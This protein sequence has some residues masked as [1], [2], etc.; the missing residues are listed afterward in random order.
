M[1]L[2]CLSNKRNKNTAA[3]RT[4]IYSLLFSLFLAIAVFSCG[5]AKIESAPLK[6]PKIENKVSWAGIYIRNTKIGW[7]KTEV[8]QMEQNRFR[9]SEESFMRIGAMGII[10]ESK[11]NFSADFNEDFNPLAYSFSMITPS[12]TM[13]AKGEIKDNV[14]HMKISTPSGETLR[15]VPIDSNT[16]LFGLADLKRAAE[17]YKVGDV[18][19]GKMFE[20]NILGIVP[21]KIEVID[22]SIVKFGPELKTVFKIR[23]TIASVEANSLVDADGSLIL[24]EGP[25]GITMKREP[26]EIA[27]DLSNSGNIIYLITAFSLDAGKFVDNPSSIR[28]AK[29]QI[30]GLPESFDNEG[31]QSISESDSDG[32]RMVTVDLDSP[33]PFSGSKEEWLMPTDYVQ[34]DDSRII[35]KAV[36]ITKGAIDHKEKSKI[37][38]D[39]V[40]ANMHREPAFTIP[41]ALDVLLSMKGD[42]NEH[43][44]LYC[45]L[46]RAAGIPAR[47]ATGI[48]YLDGRF[49]YHAWNEVLL[50]GSWFP[51][52]STF[53]EFPAGALRIRFSSG[54]LMDQFKIAG[55]AGKI[56][57]SILEAN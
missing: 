19:E 1:N 24:S 28:R 18:F 46:A 43:S 29:I 37:I 32:N 41:S 33:K 20:P 17:G 44:A 36:E 42:C 13:T 39:W 35:N 31:V 26:E 16:D 14:L 48:V 34:S 38:L 8:K 52:D 22:S 4:T 47:T 27:K 54:E 40:H 7:S 50:D 23:S 21:Y 30:R 49:Y 5:S 57:V 3:P 11:I 51:V 2:S 45:A 56:S 6:R 53:G 12:M 55:F 9:L 25:M 15:E 10:Q